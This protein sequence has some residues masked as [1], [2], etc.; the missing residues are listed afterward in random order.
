MRSD[1]DFTDV[2]IF[3]NIRQ[4][5]VYLL[6]YLKHFLLT[7]RCLNGQLTDWWIGCFLFISL[8]RVYEEQIKIKG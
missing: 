3:V 2:N 7:H 6:S 1:E 4:G 8:A 5:F